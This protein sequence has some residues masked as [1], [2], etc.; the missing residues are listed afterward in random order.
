MSVFAHNPSPANGICDF[1]TKTCLISY[2]SLNKLLD[3][4]KC[5]KNT[6]HLNSPCV[7]IF[8]DT[9]SSWI[10]MGVNLFVKCWKDERMDD[11]II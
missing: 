5:V 4:S 6:F 1:F 2:G 7:W 3:I 9:K 10:V 11:S 8:R